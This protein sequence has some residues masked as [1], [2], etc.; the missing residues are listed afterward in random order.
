M[1]ASW[2]WFDFVVMGVSQ[3]SMLTFVSYIIVWRLGKRSVTTEDAIERQD[4]RR[5]FLSARS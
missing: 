2:L 3:V 1:L 4:E 5:H